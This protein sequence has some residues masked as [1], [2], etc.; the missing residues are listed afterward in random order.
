M[1]YCVDTRDSSMIIIDNDKDISSP[2]VKTK[3]RQVDYYLIDV[4]KKTEAKIDKIKL[5]FLNFLNLNFAQICKMC[6]NKLNN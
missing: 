3:K 6:L 2:K 5:V 4:D 1:A